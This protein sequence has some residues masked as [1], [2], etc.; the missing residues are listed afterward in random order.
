M[1]TFLT[2]AASL[3]LLGLILWGMKLAR[4]VKAKSLTLFL[5]H[6]PLRPR[7]NKPQRGNNSKVLSRASALSSKQTHTPASPQLK[8]YRRM[9]HLLHNLEEHPSILPQARD[10]LI[11]LFAGAISK[12]RCS[13]STSILA[14][15]TYN[16]D[17]LATFIRGQDDAIMARFEKYSK[18][19]SAGAP[20]ELF[21]T[22]DE[23][24]SWLITRAPSKLVDGAW[25]GHVHRISTTPFDLRPITKGAW[26]VLSE[27]LGDGDL[28]KN[29]AAIYRELMRQIGAN[30]PEAYS[31]DFVE[32]ADDLG[33]SDVATWQSAVTQLL[34]SLFPHEFLGEI[35][36]F[37]LHFECLTWDTVAAARELREVGL[38]SYYF[39]LHISIDNSDSGHVAMALETV[40]SYLQHVQ[41]TQGDEALQREWRC[42]QAGYL[43]SE[44]GVLQ[45]EKDRTRASAATNTF[46]NNRFAPE[47]VRV[48]RA[49]ASV[50][51]K[52]HCACPSRIGG[53]KL[54]EWLDCGLLE[55]AQGQA[56]FLESLARARPW[57]RPG[58]SSR[59]RLVAELQWNGK[60]FGA[61]TKTELDVLCSW[62]D[63]LGV[64]D[65]SVYWEFVGRHGPSGTVANASNT[66]QGLDDVRLASPVFTNRGL[67]A[68]W[69]EHALRLAVKP[70][71]P[72]L[73]PLP[74]IPG[75]RNVAVVKKLLP[76]WFAHASLLE[77][78]VS[79]PIRTCDT[80]GS[81]V[82]RIL[83][84][85][86]GFAVE[87]E[88]VAGMDEMRRADSMGLVGLG[89]DLARNANLDP[90]RHLAD[91]L[92]LGP[93]RSHHLADLDPLG[94]DALRT[95][96]IG[97]FALDMLHWSMRPVQ[98]KSALM[99][100][101]WAFLGLHEYVAAQ[102]DCGLMSKPAR[103]ALGEIARREREA[104]GVCKR[105]LATD[106]EQASEFEAAA[107]LAWT[108]I[109]QCFA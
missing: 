43:L 28:A 4:L 61:F 97:D 93:S 51:A 66:V 22:A 18:G 10:T 27:E 14:L 92:P 48:F 83:R 21:Q 89:L 56:S 3:F 70:G 35:L 98:H 30:L 85:Q 100:M 11:S 82:I 73:E 77:G 102:E 54:S 33:M 52:L 47:L 107:E 87:D 99:G 62:I 101:S 91:V 94:Q 32:R 17:A 31:A 63:A 104:L 84:A 79:T 20:R 40:V 64:V 6:H 67:S 57:I 38:D 55:T 50:A 12:A 26:Q 13:G 88:G 90:P 103:E 69:K 19:R 9:Y 60:M 75:G 86:R 7:R 74:R 41:A 2:P 39:L 45:D 16:A 1:S 72:N 36:G 58:D 76:L 106:L 49:K 65:S 5:A 59:S 34:I 80:N 53:K 78:F 71:M 42:V 81:A 108:K 37:N 96:E 23:A 68:P 8:E 95:D 105:E 44:L 109:A 29:H 24:R 25:L 46:A 15:E